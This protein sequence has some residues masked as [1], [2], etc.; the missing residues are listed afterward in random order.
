[1]D[2]SNRYRLT[3]GDLIMPLARSISDPASLY[4]EIGSYAI[5]EVGIDYGRFAAVDNTAI[6]VRLTLDDLNAIKGQLIAHSPSTSWLAMDQ[7]SLQDK[8]GQPVIPLVNRIS[9]QQVTNYT[10]DRTQPILQNFTLDMNTGLILMFFSE[11]VNLATLMPTQITLQSTANISTIYSQSY[12]LVYTPALGSGYATSLYIQIDTLDLDQIKFL[13]SLAT[14]IENTYLSVTRTAIEDP[15]ANFVTSISTYN[16]L[17]ASNYTRDLTRP[18]LLSFDLDMNIGLITLTFDETVSAA[19][20]NPPSIVLQNDIYVPTTYYTLTEGYFPSVDSTVIS[21]SINVYDLNEIKKIRNI[22][23]NRYTTNLLFNSSLISD[24]D[25]NKVNPSSLTVDVYTPD[26]TDPYLLS[27][28]VNLTSETIHFVFSETIDSDTFDSSHLTLQEDLLPLRS[29]ALTPTSTL[30]QPED[31]TQLVLL[32]ETP[33][34]NYFKIYRDFFTNQNNTFIS[35]TSNFVKDMNGNNIVRGESVRAY[36][37]YGDYVR[38]ELNFFSLDLTKETLSL[39]FSETVDY[40]TVWISELTLQHTK[41]HVGSSVEDWTLTGGDISPVY[42]TILTVQLT[43]YDL[44]NIK[45]I[46]E[47]ATSSS[48][49]YLRLTWRFI[50]D[51]NNNSIVA[52]PESEGLRVTQFTGDTIRPYLVSYTVDLAHNFIDLTFSETIS[53]PTFQVRYLTLQS[54][55]NSDFYFITLTS[56]AS[57]SEFNATYLTFYFEHNDLTVLN[58]ITQVATSPNNTFLSHT[59]T[60]I[61][62]M[63]G[64]T[65]LPIMYTS[66]LQVDYF[67]PDSISPSLLSFDFD[68]NRGTFSLSFSETVNAAPTNFTSLIF[69]S[70]SNLTF[71]GLMGLNVS[72]LRLSTGDV[73]YTPLDPPR[74]IASCHFSPSDKLQIE[75]STDDLNLIK[76]DSN[77]CDSEVNCFLTF[78]VNA[79]VDTAGNQVSQ[80]PNGDALPVAIFY[81][82]SSS[83]SLVQFRE[84]DMNSGQLYLE[85]DEPITLNT[86]SLLPPDSLRLQR[87]FRNIDTLNPL[88]SLL[89]SSGSVDV[90]RHRRDRHGFI[91]ITLTENDLNK[92][93]E[94]DLLCTSMS[95][96][97]LSL[98]A[99][100]FEDTQYNGNIEVGIDNA[101]DL[102]EFIGDTSPP[103][104]VRFDLGI[105]SGVLNMTFDEPIRPN[106]FNA[107]LLYLVNS[108]VNPSVSYN[109][110]LGSKIAN[111]ANDLVLYIQLSQ[112]DITAIKNLTNLATERTNTYLQLAYGAVSDVSGN[113][114]HGTP[115]IPVTIFEPDSISPRLIRFSLDL[116]TDSLSFTFS[117]I[118][119]S[120]SFNL[121]SFSLIPGPDQTGHDLSLKSFRGSFGTHTITADLSSGDILDLKLN[122]GLATHIYNTYLTAA[123]NAVTDMQGNYLIAIL[124]SDPLRAFSVI[125]DTKPTSLLTFTFDLNLGHIVLTFDDVIISNTLR[126]SS[127]VLQHESTRS[128]YQR[129]SDMSYTTSPNGFNLTFVIVLSDLNDIKANPLLATDINN[130]Y[131]TIGAGLIR[132]SNDLDVLPISNDNGLRAS[133]FYPDRTAPELEGFSFDLNSGYLT[134]SYSET[135]QGQS[136]R[137]TALTL[138]SSRLLTSTSYTLQSSLSISNYTP[139]V[140]VVL[141][142]YDLNRIKLLP[143]LFTDEINAYISVTNNSIQDISGNYANSIPANVSLP[144]DNFTKDTTSP[145]LLTYDLDLNRGVVK[146]TFSEAI[147]ISS[148]VASGLTLQNVE[149]TIFPRVT[150]N[151]D[152]SILLSDSLGTHFEFKMDINDL[153][154]IKYYSNLA[155]KADDTFLVIDPETINDLSGNQ[156]VAV[157]NPFGIRVSNFTPDT[158]SPVFITFTL[159]LNL[160]V[161]LLTLVFD[162][163]VDTSTLDVSQVILQS[164]TEPYCGTASASYNN[165]NCPVAHAFSPG[166]LPIYTLTES[167]NATVVVVQI[168]EIDSNRVKYLSH[169]ATSIS[170]TVIYII[171]YAIR[172]MN[173]NPFNPLINISPNGTFY[174]DEL[175]PILRIFSLDMD[176]RIISLTFD[177]TV[178][179]D[180]TIPSQILLQNNAFS[181]YS[182]P[183]TSSY[184]TPGQDN[185]TIV[186]ISISDQDFNS[187]TA[188]TLL[189]TSMENSYLLLLN[190]AITDM[191]ANPIQ[192]IINGDALSPF[193]Y[194]PDESRPYLVSFSINMDSLRIGLTFSETVNGSSLAIGSISLHQGLSNSGGESFTFTQNSYTTSLYHTVITIEIGRADANEIKRL[195]LL[196]QSRNSTY[197][198]VTSETINDMSINSVYPNYLIANSH[199][200]DTSPPILLQFV[201]NL[202]AETIYLSFD[203]TVRVSSIDASKITIQSSDTSLSIAMYTLRYPLR[204]LT[205]YDSTFLTA[206]L[207]F[208]DLNQLKLRL[209]LATNPSNTFIAFQM[210]A[211]VDMALIPNSIVAG[212][213]LQSES[214]FPDITPPNLIAFEIDMNSGTLTFYFDEPINVTSLFIPAITVQNAARSRTGLQL[215]NSSRLTPSNGLS[216]MIRFSES[217]LNEIKRIDSLFTNLYDSYVSITNQFISDLNGNPVV[218][219][220]NGFALRASSYAADMNRPSIVTY[221]INMNIGYISISFSE[222]VNVS[223]FRCSDISISER[224]YCNNSYQLSGCVID[225]SAAVYDSQDIGVAGNQ[226]GGYGN[227]TKWNTTNFYSTEFKF[228]F[229]LYDLNNLKILGIAVDQS[230]SYLHYRRSTITD[231]RNLLLIEVNCSRPG[232]LPLGGFFADE[233]RPSLE[234]FSLSLASGLLALNFSETVDGSRLDET[235]LTFV[236]QRDNSSTYFQY[237]PLTY[238]TNTNGLTPYLTVSIST[239]DLNQ[240]KQRIRLATHISN[241]FLT[242]TDAFITD[243]LSNPI[244]AIVVSDALQVTTFYPDN[245][246]CKLLSYDL[247]MNTATFTFTFDET[248][249]ASS[250]IA[251]ELWLQAQS[252]VSLLSYRIVSGNQSTSDSTVVSLTVSKHDLNSI[253]NLTALATSRANTFIYFS[254]RFISDMN[255]NAIIP[256]L[257]TNASQVVAFTADETQPELIRFS[258]DL[259]SEI[260]SLTFSETVN[261]TSFIAS[262]LS[263]RSQ[264]ASSLFYTL[265]GGDRLTYYNSLVVEFRLLVGDLNI[266]KIDT[267]LF[268]DLNNSF[269]SLGSSLISDMN[270][271][272]IVANSIGLQASEFYG[273]FI[274]PNLISF[275]LDLNSHFLTLTFDET[276]NVGSLNI[277]DITIQ[278]RN[279]SG[280]TWTLT[281]GAYPTYSSLYLHINSTFVVIQ[282]GWIDQL[283]LK[284][285]PQLAIS[286][287][288]TYLY[289]SS[290]LI[291]DM[292]LN[293]VEPISDTNALEVSQFTPD[294]TSPEL[295]Y[296]DLDLD[297]EVLT[298]EFTEVVNA[299]SLNC[300][301]LSLAN[302]PMFS[303]S[304]LSL[305]NCSVRPFDAYILYVDLGLDFLNEIKLI[306][307]LA[308]SQ[309]NTYIYFSET[310]VTDMNGNFIVAISANQTQPVRNFTE[311]TTSPSLL[312]FELDINA[313]SVRLFFSESINVFYLDPTQIIL[314]SSRFISNTGSLY[315][316]TDGP[317]QINNSPVVSFNFTKFDLDRIKLLRDLATSSLNTHILFNI[318]ST[319]DSFALDMNFNKINPITNGSGLPVSIFTEDTTPPDIISSILDLNSSQLTIS[320]TEPID[321]L[322]TE[323]NNGNVNFY[324]SS[325]SV[326]SPSQYTLIDSSSDSYDGLTILIDISIQDFNQ[327]NYIRT[328]AF[329]EAS[330]FLYFPRLVRDMNGNLITTLFNGNND[331]RPVNT[332][333]PDRNSPWVVSFNLDMNNGIL[334]ITFN[335]VVTDIVPL[336]YDLQNRVNET[337]NLLTSAY[338]SGPAIDGPG[339]P[340]EIT[341]LISTRDLNEIKALRNLATSNTTTFLSVTSQAAKDIAGNPILATGP[342]PTSVSQFI[343]DETRHQ[344]I[345][346][347]FNLNN[348]V[349]AFTFDESFSVSST[350][351]TEISFLNSDQAPVAN[352]TLQF[353]TNSLISTDGTTKLYINISENDLNE[354]KII[355]TLL[356]ERSNSF[357]SLTETFILDTNSNLLNTSNLPLA[358]SQ[359]FPDITRPLL[360][361]FD[362]DMNTNILTLYFSESVNVSSLNTSQITL[363][364]YYTIV[365]ETT[366]KYTL[367]S[368]YSSS[369]DGLVVVISLGY[370]DMNEIKKRTRIATLS[371]NTYITL[372]AL[373]ISDMFA[374]QVNP[375]SDGSAQHVRVYV[376]DTTHPSMVDFQFDFNPGVLSLTFDETID[377][378]SFDPSKVTFYNSIHS[379]TLQLGD[380][381]NVTEDSTYFTFFLQKFDV[382]N[383]KLRSSLL[384]VA[385]TTNLQLETGTVVDLSDARLASNPEMRTNISFVPDLMSPK[386]IA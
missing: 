122:S 228:N 345:S 323:I 36:S 202:T 321:S 302:F 54:T 332:F 367:Q 119:L 172:D 177:E 354:I 65:I 191:N 33:A 360:T 123:A 366:N 296:F 98:Q 56:F 342:Y 72:T 226:A 208:T 90:Y 278:S 181:T 192:D 255:S 258:V 343:P 317:V 348:G 242:I 63:S 230:T 178:N 263:V 271:N 238:V 53:Q 219:L 1:M 145:T 279:D 18:N 305:Y 86:P 220:L 379:Y 227:A 324:N 64:N 260:M 156:V 21:I 325:S 256:V 298:L 210:D 282:L 40:A 108:Q 126:G 194:I 358:A 259:T 77:L 146:L 81:A 289:H 32:I 55:E 46:I 249:N 285:S 340:P 4:P 352:Y 31:S 264:L 385:T 292:N 3:G 159:N 111:S 206:V 25:G 15:E 207:N 10:E 268:T 294:R 34:L 204:V 250:L 247:D 375:I 164:T 261:S 235:K 344:L 322:T 252:N 315:Q 76:S 196:A 218:S 229:T 288:T 12:T 336:H 150:F 199:I 184:L 154:S 303:T 265:S 157:Y 114:I 167:D 197:L 378:S 291:R 147:N 163:T 283:N 350:Q 85:F 243:T 195:S 319:V 84:I 224:P 37:F 52:I 222:T 223:S 232:L 138:R 183:L 9:T 221:S 83:P 116:I 45:S 290:H 251:S 209:D 284:V 346:Y 149:D 329:N 130:T 297:T 193:L 357:I 241:T 11:T 13:R 73:T 205:S 16:A 316:L 115:I 320:F 185:S 368:A 373:A 361:Y 376:A 124:S 233:T 377:I 78:G 225:S 139:E 105:D 161:P 281:G 381:F 270:R 310:V 365:N 94:S 144:I 198:S 171:R 306:T 92:L 142:P 335:E 121:N 5:P 24:T 50:R 203:E 51:M 137:V 28:A 38:P 89:L 107:N 35:F 186:N 188:D 6:I 362:L 170:S 70:F 155:T 48:T 231:Q 309:S 30:I 175:P 134:L 27:F 326:T 189:A 244:N 68:L 129:L 88:E 74:A 312:R 132:D 328:V 304:R 162:E 104:L 43:E 333:I 135:V 14:N 118:V 179:I 75:I 274:R 71:A 356:T 286:N 87:F 372:T 383:L 370:T 80:I 136:L 19:T 380:L 314:S 151:N 239:I 131:V 371:T 62:D 91:I 117:E 153:N 23:T 140:V 351:Y 8:N 307:D 166:P 349:L 374:L 341:I 57:V 353:P 128:V 254:S 213:I 22:A 215:Y 79:F 318:N 269:V 143:G 7:C 58:A 17:R 66:A 125:A 280:Q 190:N 248:V 42:S 330:T 160:T 363:Q 369:S 173:W 273:D 359:V 300:Q 148:F 106:T 96:C 169:L 236:N 237:Y 201:L 49:T 67:I 217:E 337:Y 277:S 382:D 44:N 287:Y 100:T 267:G 384:H 313:G 176:Q 133:V 99:G 293:Y 152:V 386:L 60:L 334:D 182:L 272:Y 339:H 295:A 141:S 112:N 308:T 103:A 110:T 101:I 245:I 212:T 127:L 41:D 47:L 120:S 246:S 69:Q 275:N 299:S 262:A 347:T 214:V 29:I 113:P 97:W 276:V 355:P 200:P 59:S 174:P 216:F 338:L 234:S 180:T 327:L 311:D 95:N 364:A 331:T 102:Y 266:I 240:I 253:K 168:G 82:D 158:T 187:I 211:I 39:T 26:T 301:G 2:S 165:S 93:K 20:F 61:S 257:F 109:L